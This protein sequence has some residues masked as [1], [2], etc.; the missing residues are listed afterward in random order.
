VASGVGAV[1]AQWSPRGDLIAFTS[2]L[3]AGG[4]VW[5]IKPDGAALR[6]LTDGADGA[7]SVVPVWSPN[8]TSLLFQRQ[9]GG[10]VTLWTM[11]ADGTNARQLAHEPLASE[12]VGGFRW[13]PAIRQ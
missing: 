10:K 3:R 12:Y 9:A 7:T 8:G 1:S 6:Q 2:K 4:Q 13:W 11:S 5:I